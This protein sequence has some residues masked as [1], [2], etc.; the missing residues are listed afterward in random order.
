MLT[1]RSAT[2]R[3]SA[4]GSS[5]ATMAFDGSYCTPKCVAVGNGVEQLQEDVLLLGE[6]GVLPEAVLVVVLQPQDDVVLAGD[7]QHRVDAL[8]DPLQPLLAAH[9]GIALAG[10]HPADG[11]RPAQPPGDA[12]HLGL[13]IDRRACGASASGLVKS[14]EQQSIG[15]AKPASR[16][17]SPTRSM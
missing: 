9:L 7:R 5:P 2:A 12:D 17:A 13:A 16:I 3:S 6:L 1:T 15:I 10:E 4:I 8:D 14:G 11:P